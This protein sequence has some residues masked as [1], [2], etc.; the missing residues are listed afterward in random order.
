MENVMILDL[1]PK[2]PDFAR[3][4]VP[5]DMHNQG[6]RPNERR[7]GPVMPVRRYRA[8][9]SADDGELLRLADRDVAVVDGEPVDPP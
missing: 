1:G 8:G 6:H 7:R 5:T 2:T 4:W 9:G 3:S